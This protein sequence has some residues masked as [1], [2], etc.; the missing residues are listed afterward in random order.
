MFALILLIGCSRNNANSI[1]T[2]AGISISHRGVTKFT[3]TLGT[4]FLTNNVTMTPLP[5]AESATSSPQ[6]ENTP[7][8]VVTSINVESPPTNKPLQSITPSLV[9]LGTAASTTSPEGVCLSKTNRVLEIE[10]ANLINIEREDGGFGMLEEQSQLSTQARL[11]AEDMGCNGFFSHVSPINGGVLDR[12]EAAEYQFIS[13]G[14]I[15]AGGNI[16]PEIVLQEWMK[17]PIHRE[18][19]LDQKYRQIGI[20]FVQAD[21]PGLVYYWT[22][23]FGEPPN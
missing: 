20:G 12:V 2:P 4:E 17:S 5:M 21:G 18:Q 1:S 7:I 6:T 19:I 22:V 3:P 11:H 8:V 16:S 14:E 10:L 15:I 9:P 13:I 23:L